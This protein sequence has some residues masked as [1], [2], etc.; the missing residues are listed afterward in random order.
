MNPPQF[1]GQVQFS[2]VLSESYWNQLLTD[3]DLSS[4]QTAYWYLPW[5]GFDEPIEISDPPNLIAVAHDKNG[6]P[7]GIIRCSRFFFDPSFSNIAEMSFQG[8]GKLFESTV[9]S[10]CEHVDGDLHE[11]FPPDFM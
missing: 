9:K 7:V 1:F 3:F 2:N 5:L 4:I 11:G 8:T 10:I 6:R